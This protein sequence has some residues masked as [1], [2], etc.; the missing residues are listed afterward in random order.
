M[1]EMSRF[2][3][4][5]DL[6]GDPELMELLEELK[7]YEEEQ[8]R[9]WN[10]NPNWLPI[11]YWRQYRE[12]SQEELA[13]KAGV[14]SATISRAERGLP[15][16]RNTLTHIARA[17]QVSPRVIRVNLNNPEQKEES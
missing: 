12:M 2:L 17:L 16:A 14:S 1:I 10:T 13:N 8:G 11:E 9:K 15:I 5:E 6:D 7:R 4:F 3:G